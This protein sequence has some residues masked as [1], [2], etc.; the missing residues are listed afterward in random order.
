VAPQA[1]TASSTFQMRAEACVS[2][3][4]NDGTSP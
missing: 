1:S 2:R 3:L 4:C